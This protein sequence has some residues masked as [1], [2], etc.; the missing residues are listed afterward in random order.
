MPCHNNRL[1]KV[2]GMDSV[3][4]MCR[5]RGDQKKIKPMNS[6]TDRIASCLF[7]ANED[8]SSKDGTVEFIKSFPDPGNKIKLIQGRRERFNN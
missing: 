8:G 7:A 3:S 2:K 5:L 4:L 6:A 1:E